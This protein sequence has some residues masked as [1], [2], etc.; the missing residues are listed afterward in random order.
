MILVKAVS[1]R[2]VLERQLALV[3]WISLCTGGSYRPG[4]YM[5]E[6]LPTGCAVV[7]RQ[8]ARSRGGKAM[9]TAR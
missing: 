3:I 7:L 2:A 4:G 6:E 5:R 8:H 1:R 9:A